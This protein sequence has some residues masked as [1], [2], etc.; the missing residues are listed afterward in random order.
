L[1]PLRERLAVLYEQRQAVNT[2]KAA[3]ETAREGRKLMALFITEE[4]TSCGACEPECPNQAIS[5]GESV[6]VVK[7]ELCTECV[8]HF[9]ESQCVAVCPVACIVPNPEIT[10]DRDALLGKFKQLHPDK[11]P[12]LN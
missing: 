11:E 1:L 6:Y 5:E 2:N 9:A 4:C 12:V 8:G 10:E 3:R 7:P